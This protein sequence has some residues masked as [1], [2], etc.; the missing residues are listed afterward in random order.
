M[1]TGR[2]RKVW[3]LYL[4]VLVVAAASTGCTKNT[5]QERIWSIEIL[6]ADGK[7]PSAFSLQCFESKMPSNSW[8][9]TPH[10]EPLSEPL[11]SQTGQPVSFCGPANLAGIEFQG[12]WE[13]S[14]GES[15]T[16]STSEYLIRDGR[17][18]IRLA[19]PFAVQCIGGSNPLPPLAEE[20]ILGCDWCENNGAG[21]GDL[22]WFTP[23]RLPKP[24]VTLNG[25]ALPANLLPLNRLITL[26]RSGASQPFDSV[27]VTIGGEQ[28]C[29][30]LQLIIS[31]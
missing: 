10:L 12:Q 30:T 7:Q 5:R 29:D 26:R 8:W 13:S 22:H 14:D 15:Y 24:T 18:E 2:R 31:L 11:Q 27:V 21:F 19:A 28:L 3:R 1:R 9:Q 4:G 16:F 23:G 17:I 20:I 6:L 25:W